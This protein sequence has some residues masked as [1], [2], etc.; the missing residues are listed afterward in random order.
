MRAVLFDAT[1]TLLEPR[2]PVGETYARLAG[3]YGVELPAWRVSDAFRRIFRQAPPMVFPDAPRERIGELER[4]WWR[5]VVRRTFLA[6]DGTA[7]FSDFDSYFERLHRSFASADAWRPVE[8]IRELLAELRARGLAT[9]IVSNF[10]QRLI[11]I[12]QGLDLKELLD[13]VMLPS[14]ARAAKPDPRIFALALE[15]LEVPAAEAAFVGDDPERDLA[16]ARAAGLKA[17]EVGSLA[18]LAELPAR[19]AT[20]ARENPGTGADGA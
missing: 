3:E 18:T 19:I 12:L 1:G 13:V 8:G 11:G 10:D 9:G 20:A 15:R 4:E 16:G 2:E 7:R 6:A 14:E 17:I 5:T